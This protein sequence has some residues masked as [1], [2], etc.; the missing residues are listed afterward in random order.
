MGE[1]DSFW[2]ILN[3]V[4][5]SETTVVQYLAIFPVLVSYHHPV[6]PVIIYNSVENGKYI[7]RTN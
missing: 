3:F 7:Y 6:A 5:V 2:R 1:L 4:F